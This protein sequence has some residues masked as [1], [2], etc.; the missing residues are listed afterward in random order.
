MRALSTGLASSFLLV[1]VL[2]VTGCSSSNNNSLAQVQPP[3]QPQAEVKPVIFVHGQSGSAQQFET[4]AMRF[5]SNGYPQDMLFVFEYNT[6]SAVNPIAD[7]DVFIDAVLAKTGASQVYAVGHS[8]GTSV[9]TTYLDDPAF[10]GPEKVAKYVNIDGR[11][12]EALPGGIPTIGIWGEWNT[13][14]SGYSIGAENSDAQIGPDPENNFHFPNKSHTE[15]AT[16]AET[17]ALMYEF[18]AG[19]A[20]QVTAVSLADT[21]KVRVAG[22]ALLFP[23]NLGYGG[24]TVEVWE[25]EEATGQRLLTEPLASFVIGE[26]GDFGPVELSSER[27][28]E[29]ALL[30]PGTAKFP[31]PTVHHF[32]SAPYIHDNYFLRLLSSYPGESISAFLPED[33]DSTGFLALRQREFWG[34]QGAASD[35]LIVEGLN[36]LTPAISPRAVSAGSGVN[37]AVF[38][39]DD[40]SDNI[41]DL[42]KGELSPFSQLTFLTAVD[43]FIAADAIGTGS[44][45]IV[46]VTRGGSETRLNI[47]R[48]ASATGHRNS[49]MFRDDI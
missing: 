48:R 16:A 34:D 17:F 4:Q 31:E 15:T 26:S 30:R 7:L 25:I 49:V 40:E 10:S 46:L 23:E 9:W 5:T 47:P 14:N 19:I 45:E 6:A 27:L 39:Y 44:F 13:A 33:D 3:I 43:V 36:V 42:E 1:L 12:M 28:Y 38:V 11:T 35:Q 18:L 37:I 20:P 8:R 29:F 24:S 2:V 21:G 22:R 32:Y 41:T